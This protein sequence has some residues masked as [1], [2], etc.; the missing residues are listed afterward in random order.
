MVLLRVPST[1]LVQGI[2]VSV[3]SSSEGILE[4]TLA[5]ADG[6]SAW[7]NRAKFHIPETPLILPQI[8]FYQPGSSPGL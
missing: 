8:P 6:K 5:E 2:D 7:A 3:I 4:E 1:Y